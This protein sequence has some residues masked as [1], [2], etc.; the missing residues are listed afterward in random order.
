VLGGADV[1]QAMQ[2]VQDETAQIIDSQILPK[3]EG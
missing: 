3:L 1:R 2:Q